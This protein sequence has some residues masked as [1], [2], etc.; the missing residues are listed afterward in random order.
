[1]RVPK[2]QWKYLAQAVDKAGNTVDFLL[3]AKRDR[4]AALR[5]LYK[6]TGQH[7][8]PAKIAIDKSGANTAALESYNA[9]RRDTEVEIRQVRT[10]PQQCCRTGPSSDRASS[11]TDDGV[12][13]L[14]VG[15]S[16]PCWH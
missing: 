2:G 10:L 7:G 4:K 14:L 11:A 5:F 16:D 9:R 6:A 12:Q 1:M 15:R 3:T 8:T 13:V